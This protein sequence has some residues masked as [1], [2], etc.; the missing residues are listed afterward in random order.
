MTAPGSSPYAARRA[1]LRLLAALCLVAGAGCHVSGRQPA[2]QAGA[3]PDQQAPEAALVIADASAGEADGAIPFMV[4]LRPASERPVEVG[5]ATADETATAGNDYRAE[6]GTLTFGAGHTGRTITVPVLNDET[7]EDGETFTV[8]L[9][10]PVNARLADATAR[11]EIIDDDP[12][13]PEIIAN[14]RRPPALASLASLAVSGDGAMY[15]PFASDIHHYALTCGNADR[16]QVSAHTAHPRAE[17]TLVRQAP[18]T[19]HRSTTGSLDVELGVDENHDIVVEVSDDGVTAT[20]IVHCIP[21]NFPDV[22]ILK[23]TAR[24][25][26][27][28]M[29]VVPVVRLGISRSTHKFVAI[30]DTNGV[31]R[32]HL[33]GS[34]GHFR[35]FSNGPTID[36]RQVQYALAESDG[37]GL[38]DRSFH[39]IRTVSTPGWDSHDFLITEDDT[40]LFL[41]FKDATRDLSHITNSGSSTPFSAALEVRDV[42]IVEQTLSGSTRF[43]WNSW[44]HL[45]ILDCIYE[46]Y[47][48]GRYTQLNG[49]QMANGDIVGSFRTCNMVARIDRSGNTGAI[50]WQVGGTS[51]IP[52]TAYRPI[53]GD[54]DGGNEFC[55]QHNPTQ[56]GEKLVLFDNGSAC[57][58]T[59]KTVQQFSRVVEYDLSS[60]TEARFS[61]E[62]RRRSGHGFSY[63]QGGVTVLDNGNWLIAWGIPVDYTLGVDELSTISEVNAQGE[64][65]FD[66]NMSGD[67]HPVV[68]YRVYAMS[69]SEFQ[70]PWNLP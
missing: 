45:N 48:G 58:G 5:Y 62:Y 4:A 68:S 61:R 52:E 6:S 3:T 65:V 18:E 38:Y 44:G 30:M 59:R 60:G 67:G 25:S 20:Y 8:T 49:F 7:A 54:D 55:Q 15:P 28:L 64:L 51:A 56:V 32:F 14:D 16:L 69:E 50:E 22:R 41:G 33:E 34:G 36:G 57:R 31:P 40:F 43:E 66:M 37:Y 2:E 42:I 9:I 39:R 17:L 53:T 70:I 12:P 13:P 47:D 19:S 11:G 21:D 26:E 1:R 10:D 63:Y 24:A 27:H 46:D 23:K 29:V 35:A